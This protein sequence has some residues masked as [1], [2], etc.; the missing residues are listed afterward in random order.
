MK[1][2]VG[3]QVHYYGSDTA[4]HRLWENTAV[5]DG[6]DV[7]EKKAWAAKFRGPFAA[8]VVRVFEDDGFVGLSILYPTAL[9][10]H[11]MSSEIVDRVPFSNEPLVDGETED[12]CWTWPP[13]V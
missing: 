8:T 10:T 6:E 4:W 1:P 3:R 7:P 9:Y 12:G 13:R 2:T 11:N 5:R